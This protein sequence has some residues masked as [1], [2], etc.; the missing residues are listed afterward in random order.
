[1]KNFILFAGYNYYPSGGW[2]D[3]KGFFDTYEEARLKGVELKNQ[4]M[5]ADWFEVVDLKEEQE[6]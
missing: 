3:F 5:L 6:S 4:Q 2:G 1:M